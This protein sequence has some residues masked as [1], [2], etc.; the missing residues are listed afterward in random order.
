M[1]LIIIAVS[2]KEQYSS[3]GQ[4]LVRTLDAKSIHWIFLNVTWVVFTS[5][6][7]NTQLMQI[8]IE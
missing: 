8:P 7:E 1:I 3:D 5:S 2:P 6:T 4:E